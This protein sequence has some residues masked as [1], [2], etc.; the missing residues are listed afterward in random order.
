VDG[1][2]YVI[3]L[4]HESGKTRSQASL[5][6]EH[7]AGNQRSRA[8]ILRINPPRVVDL[9]SDVASESKLK[10]S[11]IGGGEDRCRTV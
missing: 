1:E 5:C 2:G 10:K 8:L 6:G 4:S 3:A 9:T 7:G 11:E